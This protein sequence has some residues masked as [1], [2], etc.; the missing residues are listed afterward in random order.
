MRTEPST[1]SRLAK[2]GGFTVGILAVVLLLVAF[3]VPR[4]S[5]HAGSDV[6]LVSQPTGELSVTPTGAFVS[7]TNLEPGHSREGRFV[8]ANLTGKPLAV[9]LHALPDGPDLDRL[10]R[11]RVAAGPQLLYSGP[12]HGL[13]AWT[14]ARL[15]LPVGGR[16]TLS[17]RIWL[18]SGIGRGYEGQVETIPVELR[19]RPTVIRVA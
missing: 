17:F 13:R 3:R 14:R 18:P 1:I 5:G 16:T 10:L 7:T 9:A 11:V 2:G 6:I 19:A 15:V 8:A 4:G 12:L